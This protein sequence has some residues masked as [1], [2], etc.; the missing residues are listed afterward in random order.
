MFSSVCYIDSIITR[1]INK[2]FIYIVLGIL[3]KRSFY[4]RRFAWRFYLK[5]REATL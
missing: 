3:D 1:L 4:L 5:E 2:S